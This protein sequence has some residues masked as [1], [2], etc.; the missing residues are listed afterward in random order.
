MLHEFMKHLAVQLD[1]LTEQ[2][3]S[4]MPLLG[5]FNLEQGTRLVEARLSPVSPPEFRLFI[6]AIPTNYFGKVTLKKIS[7]WIQK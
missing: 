5:M 4:N 3:K 1:N 7:D 6:N 2:G